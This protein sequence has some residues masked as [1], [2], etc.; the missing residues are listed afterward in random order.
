ML[1]YRPAAGRCL[2]AR[3]LQDKSAID[4]D[5]SALSAIF[6][7]GKLDF[8]G[9]GEGNTV[10]NCATP[11]GE[12][13]FTFT[14]GD[15]AGGDLLYMRIAHMTLRGLDPKPATDRR[16]MQDQQGDLGPVNVCAG[17]NFIVQQ[18]LSMSSEHTSFKSQLVL[19]DPA[20]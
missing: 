2:S 12:W 15:W 14:G 19:Q 7:T 20:V 11:T 4:I 3:N 17:S 6:S 16:G 5:M 9:A 1:R 13:A 8:I 18:V 10:I